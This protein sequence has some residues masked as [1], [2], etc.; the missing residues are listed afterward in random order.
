MKISF[1]LPEE[2]RADKSVAMPQEV[3]CLEP[4]DQFRP[5]ISP[6]T[7][8]KEITATTMEVDELIANPWN[9]FVYSI[10]L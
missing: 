2:R 5:L 4:G 1:F 9:N 8:M 7:V 3:I 10:Y 6:T